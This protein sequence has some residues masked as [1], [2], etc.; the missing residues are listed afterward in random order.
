MTKQNPKLQK[1]WMWLK[2]KE[3]EIFDQFQIIT[4]NREVTIFRRKPINEKTSSS[5]K[6]TTMSKFEKL[7]DEAAKER[8]EHPELY[9]ESRWDRKPS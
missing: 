8:K 2:P 6:D 7:V 9:G 4:L 5:S 1:V 3:L